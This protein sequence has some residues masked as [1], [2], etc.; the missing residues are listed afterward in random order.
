ML[1]N[2]EKIPA[3]FWNPISRALQRKQNNKRFAFFKRIHQGLVPTSAAKMLL[4]SL[5]LQAA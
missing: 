4:G 1:F 3:K 2:P 5:A